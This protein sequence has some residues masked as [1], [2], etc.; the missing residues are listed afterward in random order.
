MGMDLEEIELNASI[1]KEVFWSTAN[2]T[3]S[4]VNFEVIFYILA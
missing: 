3:S 4:K 1:Y 2:I